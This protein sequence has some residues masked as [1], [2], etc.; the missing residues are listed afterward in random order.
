M[1]L[2]ERVM[3]VIRRRNEE[4]R[5]ETATEAHARLGRLWTALLENH[6]QIALPEPIPAHV[7]L[8]MFA[9]HKIHRACLP[10]RR[11]PD[12]YMDAVNYL[13]LAD[14]AVEP[15]LARVCG[16]CAAYNRNT[17]GCGAGKSA[18]RACTPSSPACPD[19]EEDPQC[20]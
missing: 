5:G 19:F 9:A 18:G 16:N 13:R 11:E 4:Y 15:E 3:D 12:D 17:V 6:Y 1:R 8:L 2:L 7:V 10:W 14:E 20:C